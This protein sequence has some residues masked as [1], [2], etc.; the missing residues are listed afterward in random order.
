MTTA[1]SS[2]KHSD[3]HNLDVHVHDPSGILTSSTKG[4]ARSADSGTFAKLS[5]GNSDEIIEFDDEDKAGKG[6]KKRL[7]DDITEDG[8]KG[9]R[10]LRRNVSAFAIRKNL[11]PDYP[12]YRRQRG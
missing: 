12:H 11:E 8:V 3:T 10:A 7:H 6:S 2:A 1:P 9:H 4:N 5:R